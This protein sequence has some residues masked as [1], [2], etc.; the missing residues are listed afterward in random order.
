MEENGFLS[1]ME[2]LRIASIGNHDSPY[3]LHTGIS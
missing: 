1:V 2:I 3:L